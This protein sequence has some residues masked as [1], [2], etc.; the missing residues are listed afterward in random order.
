MSEAIDW[1]AH[2]KDPFAHH[3]SHWGLDTVASA[4]NTMTC[5][6]P[7]DQPDLL[8]TA[9]V[10]MIHANSDFSPNGIRV[11]NVH[12]DTGELSTYSVTFE[13]RAT[14]TASG[15]TIA[16]VATAAG[17]EADESVLTNDIVGVDEYVYAT[18]PATDVN[19]IGLEFNFVKI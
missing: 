1:V 15:T 3:N 10:R 2:K 12:V 13:I 19:N 11:L 18:L 5:Q 4:G 9:E 14:P 17:T 6:I 16:T 8:G 7:V